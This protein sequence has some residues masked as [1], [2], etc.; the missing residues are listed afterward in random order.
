MR[1]LQPA[2][3]VIGSSTTLTTVKIHMKADPGPQESI[4]VGTG[5]SSPLPVFQD[6]GGGVPPPS[7]SEGEA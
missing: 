2:Q 6:D 7:D 1:A 4:S 3:G 5:F